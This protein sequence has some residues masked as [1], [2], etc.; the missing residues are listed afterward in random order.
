MSV[1][2]T[3]TSPGDPERTVVLDGDDAE[4]RNGEP[5]LLR[6]QRL[7]RYVVLEPLGGGGMGEVFAA[8]DP[9]LDRRV[10]LK[11]LHPRGTRR[12][13]SEGRARLLREARAIARLSDTHIVPVYDVG[14]ID[15]EVF[16]A[17]KLIDG[18]TLDRRAAQLSSTAGGSSWSTLLP[19]LVDAARGLAAAHRAGLVHR[20]VKPTNVL[21]DA[22]DH[23]VVMDFGLARAAPTGGSS[24]NASSPRERK[25]PRA[26]PLEIDPALSAAAMLDPLESPLTECGTVVGTL[27]YM[28]PEQHEGA[29]PDARADQFAFCVMAYEMLL[30]VR[31]FGG[32]TADELLAAK[33]RGEVVPAPPRRRIPGWLSRALVRGLAAHPEARHRDME[34]LVAALTRAPM[35]RRRLALAGAIAAGLVPTIALLP[36]AAEQPCRGSSERLVGTWDDARRAEI[37]DRF[38]ASPSA[39]AAEAWPRVEAELDG[40]AQR[41]VAAHTEACEATHVRHERTTAELDASMACLEGRLIDFHALV[42]AFDRVDAT[43]AEH[44]IAAVRELAAG[45]A[46]EAADALAVGPVD[47]DAVVVEA[48]ARVR[49]AEARALVMSGRWVDAIPVAEAAVAAAREAGAERVLVEGLV[50]LGDGLERTGRVVEAAGP[51]VEAA[52]LATRIGADDGA[53]QAAIRLIRNLA[54][55]QSRVDDA[56]VWA[57]H[58]EGSVARIGE[59]GHREAELLAAYGVLYGIQALYPQSRSAFEQAIAIESA[60]D[61]ESLEVAGLRSNLGVTLDQMGLGEDAKVEHQASLE[62]TERL[63]GTHHPA[64]AHRLVDL[65][66]TELSF[67]D[68][69]D[70]RDRFA[71]ALEILDALHDETPLAARAFL[72]HGV[73]LSTLGEFAAGEVHIREAIV[74]FERIF[75]P[76]HMWIARALDDLGYLERQRGRP[77]A[78]VPLHRQALAIQQAGGG[79]DRQEV[80]R[81]RLMLGEALGESGRHEDARSEFEQ[82]ARVFEETLGADHP[83]L[84]QVLANLGH[85]ESALGRHGRA[86]EHYARSLAIAQGAGGGIHDIAALAMQAEIAHCELELGRN[87]EA[88]ASSQRALAIAAELQRDPKY[89]DFGAIAWVYFVAAEAELAARGDRQR[90]LALAKTAAQ[91]LSGSGREVPLAVDVAELVESLERKPGL[92]HSH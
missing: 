8:Y 74:R 68:G 54:Q 40:Y 31:P 47:P 72:G 79:R 29:P 75:G 28:A 92:R 53:A 82:S 55:E 34:A 24:S 22:D 70:A 12:R 32:K 2:E 65:G 10:A 60:I 84:G 18:T 91:H 17:M 41:W 33:R 67:G 73:A 39:Y 61:E 63:L 57:R 50:V 14:E 51:W 64:L 6:G 4:V 71:R 37:A 69:A 85:A 80:A 66:Y 43:L 45:G 1:D 26:S 90:A 42:N 89:D 11:V 20:D 3:P 49:V 7:G 9:E 87:Q 44:A 59:G 19:L 56:R 23:V 35:R 36:D 30:G 16:M 21:V 88:L 62:L 5:R 38:A 77:E 27:A 15:G 86:R 46:C 83:M 25:S 48:G 52:L 58:A 13:D 81:T 76:E 78:A